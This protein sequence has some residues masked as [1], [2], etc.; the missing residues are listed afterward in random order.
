LRSSTLIL[1]SNGKQ[2]D[3]VV[4]VVVVVV[5]VV[6][7][8]KVV[9][10]LVDVKVNEEV[11]VGVEKKVNL[12]VVVIFVIAVDADEL[13][14]D[15]VL[16]ELIEENEDLDAGDVPVTWLPTIEFTVPVLPEF[17]LAI[18]VESTF[19]PETEL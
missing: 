18:V 6:V 14:R 8:V 2:G 10:E 19:G 13:R 5:E 12:V 3:F 11:V 16:A 15:F 7:V 4:V 17:T 1:H 9:L